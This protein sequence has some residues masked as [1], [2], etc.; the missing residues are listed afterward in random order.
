MIPA[1]ASATRRKPPRWS[2][3]LVSRAESG[4]RDDEHPDPGDGGG[5]P[6]PAAT[7]L[8]CG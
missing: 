4:D 2:P 3:G 1:V 7:T 8:A 6:D 5:L